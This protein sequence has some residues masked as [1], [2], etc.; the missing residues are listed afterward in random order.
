MCTFCATDKAGKKD[1]KVILTLSVLKIKYNK[2]II[3][4]AIMWHV[5]Q[6]QIVFFNFTIIVIYHNKIN[7]KSHLL[8]TSNYYSP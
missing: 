1:C 2:G 7:N 5:H 3:G 4:I 6:D 8:G